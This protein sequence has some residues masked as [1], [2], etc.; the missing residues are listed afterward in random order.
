MATETIKLAGPD[1]DGNF[2]VLS[3]KNTTLAYPGEVYDQTAY[4]KLVKI[5]K[6]K[7]LLVRGRPMTFDLDVT[8][9]EPKFPGADM[10]RFGMEAGISSF[11][12]ES[13]G[14]VRTVEDLQ[15]RTQ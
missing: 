11:S 12:E 1:R 7:P 10:A 5:A 9:V 6:G 3:T 2:K 4:T 14:K 8:V 13:G 15:S